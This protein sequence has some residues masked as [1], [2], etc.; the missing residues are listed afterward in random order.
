[1]HLRLTFNCI[2]IHDP[3]RKARSSQEEH[4]TLQLILD[5][6]ARLLLRRLKGRAAER[7]RARV[8]HLRGREALL[9]LLRL[10]AVVLKMGEAKR[11]ATGWTS[12]RD[13]RPHRFAVLLHARKEHLIT[14]GLG[15][16]AGAKAPVMPAQ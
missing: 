9:L 14:N 8:V 10:L 4:Q 6:R 16:V 3:V 7:V 13:R 12:S 1:M 11:I 15:L 5:A 2:T